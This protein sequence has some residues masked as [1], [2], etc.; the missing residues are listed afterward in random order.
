VWERGRGLL[1]LVVV[2]LAVITASG[3]GTVVAQSDTCQWTEAEDE[4]ISGIIMRFNDL[5]ILQFGR[6]PGMT[7]GWI[8][9]PISRGEFSVLLVR[10]LG[11]DDARLQGTAPFS[12][13][14]THWTS[15]YI[16]ALV[17]TGIVQGD[18]GGTFRPDTPIT[19]AEAQVMLA[20]MLRAGTSI[21]LED[22]EAALASIGMETTLPCENAGP[23]NRGQ[24]LLMLDRAMRIPLY[25]RHAKP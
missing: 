23:I 7:E 16:A 4:A 6:G 24:A 18:P 21:H 8:D 11:W 1:G 14:T 20:R 25:A 5:Q 17:Q 10:A 22:A 12:D 9:L 19:Q 15:R 2:L 3:S 13:M